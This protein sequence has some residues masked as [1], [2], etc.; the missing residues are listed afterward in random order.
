MALNKALALF[1]ERNKLLKLKSLS[2]FPPILAIFFAFW[3]GDLFCDAPVGTVDPAR[4]AEIARSLRGRGSISRSARPAAVSSAAYDLA[5]RRRGWSPPGE[6]T[7]S[8]QTREVVTQK[9]DGK[10][11]AAGL[12]GAGAGAV[13][14]VLATKALEK[15]KDPDEKLVNENKQLREKLKEVDDDRK[16]LERE[17]QALEK[18]KTTLEEEKKQLEEEVEEL[19]EEADKPVDDTEKKALE[20][21]V[22]EQKKALEEKNEALKQKDAQAQAAQGEKEKAEATVQDMATQIDAFRLQITN[23]QQE[24]DAPSADALELQDLRRKL[25]DCAAE[26]HALQAELDELRAQGPE[27]I[28]RTTEIE[29]V[30]ESHRRLQQS[31]A[32]IRQLEQQLSVVQSSLGRCDVS[33]R[34]READLEAVLIE[35][36]R[37]ITENQDLQHQLS[38]PVAPDLRLQGQLGRLQGQVDSLRDEN[39]ELL[40]KINRLQPIEL[41]L[42]RAQADVASLSEHLRQAEQDLAAADNQRRADAAAV[43]DLNRRLDNADAG[44]RADAATVDEWEAAVRERD[45]ALEDLHGRLE[46]LLATDAARNHELERLNEALAAAPQPADVVALRRRVAELERN[47]QG[48]YD[49]NK[50]LQDQLDQARRDFEAADGE[51]ERLLKAVDALR[52]REAQAAAD[53]DALIAQH[54][55]F[56]RRVAEVEEAKNAALDNARKSQEAGDE[57]KAER[58]RAR[59]ELE[60]LRGEAQSL[61]QQNTA[62]ESQLAGLQQAAQSAGGLRAQNLT[63]QQEADELRHHLS[64]RAAAEEQ[65]EPMREEL[66]RLRGEA[67]TLQQEKAQLESQLQ[68][69]Q[70]AAGD[71]RGV[72]DEN[73]RLKQQVGQLRGELA[74]QQRELAAARAAAEGLQGQRAGDQAK[75]LELEH[76]LELHKVALEECTGKLDI[77]GKFYE[78]KFSGAVKTL[79]AENDRLQAELEALRG[80]AGGADSLLVA[81]ALVPPLPPSSTLRPQPQ[82]PPHPQASTPS[83]TH[84]SSRPASPPALAHSPL[85]HSQGPQ[86]PRPGVGFEVSQQ[87]LQTGTGSQQGLLPPP[88]AWTLPPPPPH[89]PWTTEPLPP[90]P[91]HPPLSPPVPPRPASPPAP[92]QGP[93]AL[94]PQAQS[95]GL[96]SQGSGVGFGVL[97]RNLR[98]TP[99]SQPGLLPS[100]AW[101]SPAPPASP[102]P[103]SHFQGRGFG[104]AGMTGRIEFGGQHGR[105]APAQPMP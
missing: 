87:P 28:E 69:H 68:T 90:S 32:H 53:R 2:F 58:D 80:A 103:Q 73:T 54:E 86:S 62:L 30:Q 16:E 56:Q 92:A 14:G 10:A 99:G 40:T 13:G 89:S 9:K 55:A 77:F 105:S 78:G 17:K 15:D 66:E 97:Q 49:A 81:Q 75:V 37:L 72:A 59:E 101:D 38:L 61:H 93:R 42:A 83:P 4:Q 19:K 25:S 33:H 85:A 46:R 94:S 74:E 11:L 20:E 34:G 71:A 84:S 3:S 51:R 36:N 104:F 24:L 18:E 60:R 23:L 57:L 88:P 91:M 70:Q 50:A 43:A 27:I 65:M 6:P 7:R 39:S 35:R 47:N 21:E 76:E 5:M 67:Q 52:D 29:R 41:A 79:Q 44:R 102:H 31:L 22:A 95:Q 96:Q 26:N 82:S 45:A 1:W 48:F 64:A 8:V 98:A 100:P 63:L 12:I